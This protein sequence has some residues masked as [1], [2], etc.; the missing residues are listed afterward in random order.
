MGEKAVV[1]EPAQHR[2]SGERRE[3]PQ[4]LE[5]QT[6]EQVSETGKVTATRANR[7]GCRGP[8]ERAL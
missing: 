7:P 8:G 1:A 4:C 2:W 6:H 5:A 3:V